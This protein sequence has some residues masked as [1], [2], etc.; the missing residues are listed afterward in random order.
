MK[1]YKAKLLTNRPSQMN[2][3]LKLLLLSSALNLN[4]VC[5]RYQTRSIQGPGGLI[6][7]TGGY[8]Y[9]DAL[10]FGS[11]LWVRLQLCQ[12]K[13]CTKCARIAAGYGKSNK[14]E[15]CRRLLNYKNCCPRTTLLTR[16]F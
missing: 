14:R 15:M 8:S 11:R 12:S 3:V 2:K 7:K 9:L 16:G 1:L 5:G 4:A 13:T 10:K 6:S